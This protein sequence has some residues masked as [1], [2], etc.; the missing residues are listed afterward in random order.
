MGKIL[1]IGAKGLIGSAVVEALGADTCIRAS[2]SSDETVDISDPKSLQALFGRVGELDGIVCTGGAARFKPWDQQSDDDWA[3][4]LANKLMGQ[5]NVVR[6]GA[7]SVRPGGAITLTTGVLAQHP[8]PGG[9]MITTVNDA[10]EAF[11]RAVAVE[12]LQVR[13]NAVSPGW[14][15]ETLQAMGRDPSAGIPAAEVAAVMVRQ[16]REGPAGTIALA[17]KG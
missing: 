2:R 10:V 12:Q 1:V 5:V 8:M 9:A 14:V 3:F 6:Y 4:C 7:K 16:L 11:V 13:V 15:S 17:A